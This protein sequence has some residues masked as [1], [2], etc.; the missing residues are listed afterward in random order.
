MR[1]IAVGLAGLWAG[2]ALASA[3]SAQTLT[4]ADTGQAVDPPAV[5][6]ALA[7]APV[8]ARLG[9]G[10]AVTVL[11]AE[12]RS[13]GGA[14]LY[15]AAS[16]EFLTLAV[17]DGEASVGRLKLKPGEAAVIVLRSGRAEKL[18][19][20]AGRLLAS[21]PPAAAAAFGPGLAQAA[22]QQKRRRFWGL[23][24]ATGVNATAPGSP[25]LEETRRPYL[26]QPAQIELRAAA[27]GDA[28]RLKQLTADRFVAALAARD[29]ATVAALLDPEPFLSAGLAWTSARSAFAHRMVA[30]PLPD[31]LT[32]ARAVA[33][34]NAFTVEGASQAFTLEL[35]GRDGAVFVTRLEPR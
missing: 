16:T 27:G 6:T 9:A 18:A 13:G 28:G 14:V 10:E 21:A 11:G 12:V 24:V 33:A 26:M 22:E 5:G 35:V 25:R 2:A 34:G 32:G 31:S 19:F 3:A 17:A 30:G 29:E 1:T 7:D 20:D 15:V 23:L 4:R 8:V